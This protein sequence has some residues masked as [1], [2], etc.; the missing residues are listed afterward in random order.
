M[1]DSPQSL[2]GKARAAKL[3]PERRSEIAREAGRK[4]GAARALALSPER[5]SE[6][7]QMG[8]RTAALPEQIKATKKAIR[9]RK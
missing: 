8:G 3:S 4:G 6:I 7:A 1:S 9:R 5:R 2:G